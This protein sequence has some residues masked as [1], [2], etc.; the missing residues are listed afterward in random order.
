ME[1][2][3]ASSLIDLFSKKDH[4]F[5]TYYDN[6]CVSSFITQVDPLPYNE[7]DNIIKNNIICSCFPLEHQCLIIYHRNI[8]VYYNIIN[9]FKEY[10][11][12][13]LTSRDHDFYDSLF[14]CIINNGDNYE[15][16]Y[17]NDIRNYI[18]KKILNT[19]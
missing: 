16:E 2:I 7:I 5:I 13:K 19:N 15:E 8:K 10:N 1:D 9:F 14:T 11:D 12:G 18:H 4:L 6:S 3:F 17:K